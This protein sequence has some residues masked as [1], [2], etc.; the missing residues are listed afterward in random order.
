[1]NCPI[2][3]APD[4]RVM[5]TLDQGATIERRRRCDKCGHRYDTLELDAQQIE[6]LK[7]LQETLRWVFE[8]VML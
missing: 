8:Q 1:M 6:K 3:N 2:C 5:R 4:A 7:S